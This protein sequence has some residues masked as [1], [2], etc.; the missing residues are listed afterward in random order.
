MAR[1]GRRD[2]Y[3]TDVACAVHSG[4]AKS[5]RRGFRRVVTIC[6]APIDQTTPA[7][8]IH[9]HVDRYHDCSSHLT[10]IAT[11]RF[12]GRNPIGTRKKSLRTRLSKNDTPAVILRLY[13][14]FGLS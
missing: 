3:G 14:G 5:R 13:P 7:F 2:A 4:L 8:P 9:L 6:P 1:V 10:T 12:L 11:H